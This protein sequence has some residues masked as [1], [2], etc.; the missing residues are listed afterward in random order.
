VYAS[1]DRRAFVPGNVYAGGANFR[2]DH[3]RRSGSVFWGM[4]LVSLLHREKHYVLEQGSKG[5]R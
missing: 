2:A 5:E 1:F 3:G 4:A